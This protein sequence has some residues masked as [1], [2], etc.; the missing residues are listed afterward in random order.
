M[1][2]AQAANIAAPRTALPI[3]SIDRVSM[4][5]PFAGSFNRWWV[6]RGGAGRC[7]PRRRPRRGRC[8]RGR[9]R[10][11]RAAS[12]SAS[13]ES[14][15]ESCERPRAGVEV[16]PVACARIRDHPAVQ[17]R[18]LATTS[19]IRFEYVR[20]SRTI[21]AVEIALSTS[22]C[23]VPAFIRVEPDEHLRAGLDA[24][25]DVG[26]RGHLGG[27][28]GRDQHGVGA[29]RAAPS[30]QRARDVRRPPAGGEPDG[31]V[32]RPH[33]AGVGGAGVAVVLD[34]LERA[35]RARRR[36][37]RGGR[38]RD[39]AP[40]RTSAAARR[41]PARR[42]G[43]RCRRRSSARRHPPSSAATARST[44]AAMLGNTAATAGATWASSSLIRTSRSR[45][46]SRSRSSERG[47]RRSVGAS[48]GVG[49]RVAV[50]GRPS[51]PRAGRAPRR[52]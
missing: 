15:P 48:T 31:E 21:V 50:T 47:W 43:R 14:P 2:G 12:R 7:G 9:R 22:F 11:R 46:G 33:R 27:R 29:D 20:P 32:A 39:R 5:V 8:G 38:R 51:G 18:V 16:G 6:R 19:V 41:R 10:P 35:C 28:V 3:P 24:D 17:L 37:R 26:H 45:V 13:F 52:G 25:V 40:A 42:S 23:A 30:R 34:V 1:D 4:S 49:R 36:P 44:A